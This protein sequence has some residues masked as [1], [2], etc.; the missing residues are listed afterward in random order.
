MATST[1][2]R[3]ETG[4]NPSRLPAA[5][6]AFPVYLTHNACLVLQATDAVYEVCSQASPSGLARLT[7][8]TKWAGT[9]HS[10]RR[11]LTGE[12]SGASSTCVRRKWSSAN[13][14]IA[15]FGSTEATRNAAPTQS[16]RQ[17][18]TA[19]AYLGTESCCCPTQADSRAAF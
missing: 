13:S 16:Q 10:S 17:L 8:I 9:A 19:G 1:L 5:V 14:L 11:G 7:G 15:Q 18:R 3:I 12:Y 4:P 2:S 6:G